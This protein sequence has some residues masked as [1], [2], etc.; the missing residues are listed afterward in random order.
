MNIYS[1]TIVLSDD[2][3][4]ETLG[5][6]GLADVVYGIIDDCVITTVDNQMRLTFDREA[7][8]YETATLSATAQVE[9]IIGKPI[10][11][12]VRGDFS[13]HVSK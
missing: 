13:E 1:F 9:A 7:D 3:E 8:S 2:V 10:I 5:E 12:L 6:D 4:S 11:S